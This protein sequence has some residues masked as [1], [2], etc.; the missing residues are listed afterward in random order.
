MV[1]VYTVS[2]RIKTQEGSSPLAAEG[3]GLR[4]AKV[5]SQKWFLLLRAGLFRIKTHSHGLCR[6][7]GIMHIP[8][9]QTPICW[10]KL[11]EEFQAGFKPQTERG[12]EERTNT[13]LQSADSLMLS[14]KYRKHSHPGCSF[15]LLISLRVCLRW[16]SLLSLVNEQSRLWLHARLH[17]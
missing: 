15:F 11:G 17:F 1:Q 12:G 10:C 4:T 8:R 13:R 14:G 7:S 16:I 3:T 9:L 6:S 5:W 2:Q